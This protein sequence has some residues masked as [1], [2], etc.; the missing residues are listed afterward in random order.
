MVGPF[1]ITEQVGH[2][3]KL[4]LPASMQV[5]NVFSSNRLPNAADGPRLRQVNELPPPIIIDNIEE[6][7]A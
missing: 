4:K 3:Y 2:S 1:E 6:R 5:H 7:E